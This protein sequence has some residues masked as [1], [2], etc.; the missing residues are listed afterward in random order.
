[1]WVLKHDYMISKSTEVKQILSKI[2]YFCIDGPWKHSYVKLGYEL[3][4]EQN[5]LIYQTMDVYTF[6][7]FNGYM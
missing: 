7:V 4:K 3:K 2:A 1:M 5:S 6:D